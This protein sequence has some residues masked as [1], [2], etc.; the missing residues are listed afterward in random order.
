MSPQQISIFVTVKKGRPELT[1]IPNDAPNFLVQLM[2]LCWD[3]NP[4]DRPSFDEIITFLRQAIKKG[5][6]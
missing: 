3:D 6:V 4:E 2:K 1:K 5:L